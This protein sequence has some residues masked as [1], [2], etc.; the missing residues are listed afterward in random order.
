MQ[1]KT[2]IDLAPE[3]SHISFKV[4][5]AW[6]VDLMFEIEQYYRPQIDEATAVTVRIAKELEAHGVTRDPESGNFEYQDGGSSLPIDEVKV[7]LRSYVDSMERTGRIIRKRTATKAA[8]CLDQ[9]VYDGIEWPSIDIDSTVQCVIDGR[10]KELRKLDHPD[11]LAV[12]NVYN[13]LEA[14]GFASLTEQEIDQ[15]KK[16]SPSE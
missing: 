16:P 1:N 8:V 12:T 10:Y 13:R 7:L 9:V 6:Q 5:K 15:L 2:V 3:R 14:R 11:L 4:P